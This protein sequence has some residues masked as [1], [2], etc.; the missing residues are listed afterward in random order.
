MLQ[1]VITISEKK[2]TGGVHPHNAILKGEMLDR[3]IVRY[4]VKNKQTYYGGL[5]LDRSLIVKLYTSATVWEFKKEVSQMLGLAP[6]YLK[7]TLHNDEVLRDNQHGMTLQQLNLKNGDI[8]T[9][10]KLSIVENITEL[11]LVDAMTKQLVPRAIEIFSEWYDLYKNQES[12]MM[13]A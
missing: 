3:V 8:L 11:P 12:G 2:G 13:D 1:T 6:K 4:M 10:E 5:K 9:A 7:I